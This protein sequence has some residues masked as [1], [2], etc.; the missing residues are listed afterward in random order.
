ME[1]ERGLEGGDSMMA[2]TSEVPLL[3]PSFFP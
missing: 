2:M 3:L 1:R